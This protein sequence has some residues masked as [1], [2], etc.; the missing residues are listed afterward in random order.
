MWCRGAPTGSAADRRTAW[1]GR[2]ATSSDRR[3]QVG[4][5]HRKRP[6]KPQPGAFSLW[7]G[8]NGIVPAGCPLLAPQDM[9][10]LATRPA[11]RPRSQDGLGR[12]PFAGFGH[13]YESAHEARSILKGHEH[14]TAGHP[15]V[16]DRRYPRLLAVHRRVRSRGR[17]RADGPVRRP[18]HRGRGDARRQGRGDPWRRGPRRVRVGAPG[19]PVRRRPAGD[20]STRRPR[21]TTTSPSAWGSGS[22]PARRWRS[23]TG[24]SAAP[25]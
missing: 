10:R 3:P 24:A 21:S 2:R 12:A 19:D 11:R 17:G 22:T 1:L 5:P 18:R 8:Q 16:P 25:R 7:A 9:P 6:R 13:P 20:A 23:R 15:H 14:G 4:S